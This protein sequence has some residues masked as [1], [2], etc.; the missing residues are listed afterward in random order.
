[1]Q[2]ARPSKFKWFVRV[3]VVGGI[4]WFAWSLFG[5]HVRESRGPLT[6]T[7]AA[8][9]AG[10]PIPP[11]ALN[12]RVASY[13]QW[14]EYAKYIRFEA[15]VDV[16]LRHASAVVPGA[17]LQPANEYDLAGNARTIRPNVFR[18]FGWFDLDT[19]QNVVTAGGGSGQSQVWV[20]QARGVFYLRQT[21]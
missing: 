4:M 13:S 12:V 3:A 6:P 19:A 7:A 18:D 1:M 15:P 5:L 9:L 16:C 8:S 2:R 20:D 10:I 17:R 14:I 21:D 11:E